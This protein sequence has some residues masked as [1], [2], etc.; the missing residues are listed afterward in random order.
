M[1]E[2]EGGIAGCLN[3]PDVISSGSL[4]G[5]VEAAQCDHNREG[6]FHHL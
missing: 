5:V 1:I 3:V 6:G 2:L 4:P